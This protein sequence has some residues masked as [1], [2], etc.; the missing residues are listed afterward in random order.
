MGCGCMECLIDCVFPWQLNESWNTDAP[1]YSFTKL[2]PEKDRALINEYL[3]HEGK[4]GGKKFNQG[5]IFK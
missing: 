5:K 2:D 3:M 4:F 1:S